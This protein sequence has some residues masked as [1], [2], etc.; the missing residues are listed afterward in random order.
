MMQKSLLNIKSFSLNIESDKGLERILSS[1]NLDIKEGEITGLVGQTGSGKTMISRLILDLLPS[2]ARIENGD[3]LYNSNS[4]L[5][6]RKKIR[7][8]EIAIIFQDP[9]GSMNPLYTVSQHFNFILKNRFNY[10][11]K[12]IN[13]IIKKCLKDVALINIA[14]ITKKY[15]HQLSGGQA[16]RVMIALAISVNPKLIIADEIT[17]ALD[18]NLKIQTLDLLL[19]LKDKLN[20]S[21]LL[22]THD[23]LIAKRYCTR[24]NIIENGSIVESGKTAAIFDRPKHKYT[25]ELLS[26]IKPVS[27]KHNKSKSIKA[28]LVLTAKNIIKKYNT[29]KILN[30]ISLNLYS[31]KTLG[32]IGESGSG[33]STLAKIILKIIP[34]DSGNVII[35]NDNTKTTASGSLN[36][37][38]GI[39]FQNPLESLNPKM[40]INDSI[41][42]PLALAGLKDPQKIKSK[43]YNIMS[44]VRLQKKLSSKYPH[45]LS[46]G[47]RQRVSIARAL[48][49]NPKILILDEP[50]SSLDLSVQETIID[51]LL[52][53]QNDSNIS[54]L[55]ISHDINL[56][57]KISDE[58]SVLYQGEIIENGPTSQIINNPKNTYTKSLISS[59]YDLEI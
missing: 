46:G 7:G 11:Q 6:K 10:T 47:Q 45:E 50:T 32:I 30:G 23:L 20:S 41:S 19:S 54:Y 33:K 31:G 35:M 51:L 2:G 40:T 17:T 36:S 16:Q 52:E 48:I 15:P 12:D 14:G 4:I 53:L 22:I 26:K 1:I 57:S 44:K 28:P 37:N 38:I 8:N 34:A 25:K 5:D 18:A 24:I 9:T 29:I 39:V 27:L 13:H 56:V 42:E 59:V 43:V 21:V 3:I 58:I 49:L 55:F